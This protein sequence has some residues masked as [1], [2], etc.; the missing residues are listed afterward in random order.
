MISKVRKIRD[1]NKINRENFD[2]KDIFYDCGIDFI[3]KTK[4]F[5]P[6]FVIL[7]R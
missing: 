3:R 7:Q 1:Y 2:K 6:K 4:D 5:K